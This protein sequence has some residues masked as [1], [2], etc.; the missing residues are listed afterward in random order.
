M[1]CSC[2]SS[3][4]SIH[5]I[6][7]SCLVPS[8]RLITHHPISPNVSF[9]HPTSTR[10]RHPSSRAFRHGSGSSSSPSSRFGLSK[11]NRP[12]VS[13][14]KPPSTDCQSNLNVRSSLLV[15]HPP[16]SYKTSLSDCASSSAGRSDGVMGSSRDLAPFSKARQVFI[17]WV[18]TCHSFC[19]FYLL[20]KYSRLGSQVRATNQAPPCILSSLKLNVAHSPFSFASSLR[21]VALAH[22]RPFKE[23]LLDVV[24]RKQAEE[25]ENIERLDAKE[26]LE[27]REWAA[28]GEKT[29][30]RE[31]RQQHG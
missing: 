29:G 11:P 25:R 3:I 6:P 15:S 24:T 30:L 2:S 1:D 8:R 23:A 28:Y 7:T 9:T 14:P 22:Y 13:T 12:G 4:I 16:C 17:S 21:R 18:L 10:P 20:L 27:E 26:R 5:H 19:F 31:R